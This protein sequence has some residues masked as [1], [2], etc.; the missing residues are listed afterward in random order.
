MNG[1]ATHYGDMPM[2]EPAHPMGWS[3]LRR[4]SWGA[5]FAGTLIALVAQLLFSLLGLG[6]GLGTIDPVEESNPLAG[7][8]TGSIIWW[9]ITML[10]SLFLGGW[11]AGRL[12]GIPKA[13]DSILHGALAFCLFTLLSFYLLTTTVGK[14]ISGVG[15]VIGKTVSLAGQGV[16]A[17]A[18]EIGNAL[19]DEAQQQNI[20]LSSIKKE[21]TLLLQQTGKEELQPGN[22]KQ[23]AKSLGNT[24]EQKAS[25]VAENPQSV[26]EAAGNLVDQLF[27]QGKDITEEIDKEA[28]ANVIMERTGKTREEANQIASNWIQTFEQGKAELKETVEQG[29]QK[30]EEVADQTA[31][32]MSKAGIFAFFGL[33]LGAGAAGLGGKVGEP[34]DV[35][36]TA[37]A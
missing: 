34:H 28:V 26:D 31:Q 13:F 10:I 8:G 9:S 32:A 25:N 27:A 30:A 23:E 18:P 33:L 4:I 2:R 37:N 17:V 20:D 21:A 24:A 11:V 15:S 14:I 5:V 22:L 36:E 1:H 16:S 12:A 19:Q 6:I 29:K 7:L 35:V 3:A